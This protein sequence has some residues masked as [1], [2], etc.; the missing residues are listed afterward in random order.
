[1]DTIELPDR[2]FLD[3]MDLQFNFITNGFFDLPTPQRQ[4]NFK[5]ESHSYPVPETKQKLV[6]DRKLASREYLS[7]FLSERPVFKKK[8]K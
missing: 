7:P 4:N 5:K 6:H 3:T 2:W 8:N 1:M